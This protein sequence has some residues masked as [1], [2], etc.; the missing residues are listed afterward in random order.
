MTKNPEIKSFQNA[1]DFLGKKD[2]RKIP[3][4]RDTSVVRVS[5]TEIA[6]KYHATHVVTYHADG[7]IVLN[8]GN[9]RSHTTK[10]RFSEHVPYTL[11]QVFQKNFTW[12]VVIRLERDNPVEFY[13]GFTVMDSVQAAR[14]APLP[15]PAGV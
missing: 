8:S 14:N 11:A 13:D 2:Y 9:W 6:V 7:A 10:T 12:Y 4:K 1:S 15:V 5:K 3:S